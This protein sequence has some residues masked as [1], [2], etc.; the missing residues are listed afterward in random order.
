MSGADNLW[1][2]RYAQTDYLFGVEP[3]AFLAGQVGRLRPGRRALAVADGEGRNGVWLAQQGLSV[4]SVDS[5]AVAQTKARSLAQA[6]G[7]ALDFEQVD[8]SAW[9]WP[10][11]EFDLVVAIFIQFAT[12]ALRTQLFADMAHALKP[13]GL[14]LLQGYRPEQITYGTGGPSAAENLYTEPLLREAFAGLEIIELQSH[15]T[16]IHEGAGHDGLSALI[17]LV[18]RRPV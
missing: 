7:V 10:R 8:L 14:L 15:D 6:R 2:R 18:A 11:A 1:D 9:T 16:V 17:D 13:G 12:P 3:N 5:S 4:L